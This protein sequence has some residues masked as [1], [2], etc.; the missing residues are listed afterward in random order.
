MM[1]AFDHIMCQKMNL[2]SPPPKSSHN[3]SQ[4][5][6]ALGA[7]FQAINFNLTSKLIKSSE[8]GEGRREN[9]W[10]AQLETDSSLTDT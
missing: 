10:A 2:W 4:M 7:Y 3:F 6:L 1:T 5:V 8:G 9:E